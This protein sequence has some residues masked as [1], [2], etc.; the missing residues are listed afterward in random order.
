[1]ILPSSFWYR[2]DHKI[3]WMGCVR[4]RTLG[5]D[6][7]ATQTRLS[8]RCRIQKLREDPSLSLLVQTKKSDIFTIDMDKETIR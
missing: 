1:M 5:L 6:I 7:R 2:V 3:G 8:S 4:I